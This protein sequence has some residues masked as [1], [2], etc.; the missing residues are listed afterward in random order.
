MPVET[1]LPRPRPKPAIQPWPFRP[2]PLPDELLSS[3]LCRLAV[4]MDLKPITFLNTVFGSAKNLLAQDLDNF[5]PPRIV[6][7]IAL[8]TLRPAGEIHACTLRAYAGTLI[9][10]HNPKGRNPWLLPTTIDNN[11]RL[12]TGLQYC[13][14]CLATDAKPYFRRRW[15]L[16]F[17]TSCT[18]HG[19]L[20]RDRCPQCDAPVH[21]HAAASAVH[22]FKCGGELC[23]QAATVARHDHIAWQS[24]LE[25]ALERGWG[26]LGDE[27][28]RAHVAFAIVRQV[29]ALLVNGRHAQA[30][31]QVVARDW[32][33]D[34]A[35]YEKP[36]ARQ[37]FEYLDVADRHR[38]FDMVERLMRGWPH[39]F[40]HSCLE[41]GM[42]RSHAI[43]DMPNPPFAYER[44]MRAYMDATPYQAT[45]PEVAAAA[46]WLRRTRGKA[47][48]RDLRAIC[49]ESRAAIYRHMDYERRQAV[50]SRWRTEAMAALESQG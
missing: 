3:Y 24:M 19:Q 14:A 43:K 37:P 33:G 25:A 31:R 18:T 44:V 47:T 11:V 5:A 39:R 45:E 17:V 34:P 15:R 7:R 22:C 27:H 40:V 36:T 10:A 23:E 8:G 26:P 2:Q 42:H 21:Q 9:T 32:G 12:R 49:G 46:A 30:L 48:Y 20:L 16:A 41:A 6:E 50:P 13:P 28:L 38:L 1:L 29:A 4:G 35:P